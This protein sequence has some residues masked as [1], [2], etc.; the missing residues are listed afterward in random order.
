MENLKYP[1]GKFETK[2]FS[3]QQLSDWLLDI[4]VLPKS[5]E[6]SIANLDTYQL[7]EPYRQDGWTIKQVVHHVADSHTNALIRIKL[8][9]TEDNPIIKP[10][11]E[12]AWANLSDVELVPI[13]I[14]LT[15]IHCVHVKMLALF[16]SMQAADWDKTIYHP[17]NKTTVT[18]W[19]MLGTYAWHGKHHAAHINGLRERRNWK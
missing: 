2:P 17:A 6:F 15:I 1:I 12:A 16:K 3:P 13:N 9:L 8:G 11:D 10:Y 19:E 5:L 4:E 18:L 14:S 7:N